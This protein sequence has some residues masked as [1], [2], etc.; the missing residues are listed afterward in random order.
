MKNTKYFFLSI[1][2]FLVLFASF[3]YAQ[4]DDFPLYYKAR[5]L[6]QQ[7]EYKKAQESF[8]LLKK[9]YPNSIYM[10]DAGFWSAYIA[11]K[12]GQE[13]EAFNAYNKLRK[14]YPQ[15]PWVDDAEA[16][17]I[18]I[19][20]KLARS[21]D[22]RHVNFIVNKLQSP[23][24]KIKYRAALSLGKLGDRRALPTLRRMENNGDKDMGSVAKSLIRDFEKGPVKVN[25]R[26][27]VKPDRKKRID[28]FPAKRRTI[29]QPVS[30]TSKTLPGY[31]KQL[32]ERKTTKPKINRSPRRSQT[33]SR[34][35]A[36]K[37]KPSVQRSLPK[38]SSPAKKN[39]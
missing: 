7:R 31:Q 14:K 18:D 29:K 37:T 11:E 17:Q 1:L 22:N 34:A 39:N 21:G 20:E 32:K 8:E 28:D 4:Q 30:R 19:A 36:V 26:M 5:K 25:P 10:D 16:H 23:D 13:T 3:T 12:Q 24:K 2:F 15:S 6:L 35:P 27:R 33:K 38:K 9:K